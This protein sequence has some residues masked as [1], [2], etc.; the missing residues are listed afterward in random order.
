MFQISQGTSG[1][2]K[3]F[4]FLLGNRRDEQEDLITL[5]EGDFDVASAKRGSGA[6]LK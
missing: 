1:G 2:L 5:A 6:W 4:P 3:P